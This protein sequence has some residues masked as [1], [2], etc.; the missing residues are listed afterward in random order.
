MFFCQIIADVL[1]FGFP[2]LQI[3]GGND[4]SVAVIGI[5][6]AKLFLEY[7][8][9]VKI[10]GVH[11]AVAH[12]IDPQGGIRFFCHQTGSDK[13]P[14]VGTVG[15]GIEVD[16]RIP[17]GA[18]GIEEAAKDAEAAIGASGQR[19]GVAFAP[20]GYAVDIAFLPGDKNGTGDG[21]V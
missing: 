17:G 7:L 9:T 5:A 2:V 19:D 21:A 18:V 15:V 12:Q 10:D 4:V 8:D 6:L 20:A 16:H 13:L 1:I 14:V 11:V 3:D